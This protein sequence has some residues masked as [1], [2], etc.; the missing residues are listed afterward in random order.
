MVSFVI[1]FQLVEVEGWL[2]YTKIS[3]NALVG[4]FLGLYYRRHWWIFRLFLNRYHLGRPN[5]GYNIVIYGLFIEKWIG[6][7]DKRFGMSFRDGTSIGYLGQQDCRLDWSIIG[8]EV[9]N[10]IATVP[11]ETVPLAV[12]GTRLGYVGA[13]T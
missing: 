5:D 7:D 2:R 4:A 8:A 10:K 3:M 1:V 9:V 12:E 13:S 11:E 6:C